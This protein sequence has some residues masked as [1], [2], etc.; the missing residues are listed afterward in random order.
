M[1]RFALEDL[2]H[3]K[4]EFETTDNTLVVTVEIDAS[5]IE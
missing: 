2:L 3:K 1:Y 5:T 4:T